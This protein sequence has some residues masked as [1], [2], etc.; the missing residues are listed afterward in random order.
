MHVSDIVTGHYLKEGP[1]LQITLEAI[2]VENNR[3]LWRDTM[4]VAA[5]DMIAM[6]GQIT[7]KIRQ[8]LVPALGAGSGFRRRRH[9]PQE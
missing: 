3:T 1:Q 6:R 5:P 8:G 9:A 4:S 7:S 2:D